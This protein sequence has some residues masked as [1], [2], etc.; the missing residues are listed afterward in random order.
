[1]M[2]KHVQVVAGF[3]CV[4]TIR[5]KDRNIGTNSATMKR[6]IL[7]FIAVVIIG[8]VRLCA[9]AQEYK[10]EQQETRTAHVEQ[11]NGISI[12]ILSTPVGE[13]E[14]L[15]T[16]SKHFAL[17]GSNKEMINGL[18]KKA[19]KDYSQA[20]GLIFNSLDFEKAE[21]IKFK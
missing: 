17:T 2:Q 7:F 14:R 4:L 13:Y 5:K 12:F 20:Q 11:I 21:V 9:I 16:V 1:M 6:I 15:G 18:V 3:K 19:V 8:T 10:K